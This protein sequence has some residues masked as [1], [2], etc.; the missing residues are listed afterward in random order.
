MPV[1][2]GSYVREKSAPVLHKQGHVCL[3]AH[4]WGEGKDRVQLHAPPLLTCP[5]GRGGVQGVR[6]VA[7]VRRTGWGGNNPTF[8]AA[9]VDV[10]CFS[11]ALA[12][13]NAASRA[14]CYRLGFFILSIRLLCHLQTVRFVAAAVH[15]G[16]REKQENCRGGKRTCQWQP[17]LS[18]GS[19][20][21]SSLP[22][23]LAWDRVPEHATAPDHDFSG[24]G[25]HEALLTPSFLSL[26]S[27]SYW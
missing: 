25:V 16:T 6:G 5:R 21:L 4:T 8:Q 13:E 27:S 1:Q 2:H 9:Q 18:R 12:R 14:A 15:E 10:T 20:A 24:L 19:L 7:E 22:A 26:N 17:K 23:V 3:C 11:E